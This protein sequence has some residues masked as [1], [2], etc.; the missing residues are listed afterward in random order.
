MALLE[1]CEATNT[2]PPYVCPDLIS[3]SAKLT[4]INLFFNFFPF[5]YLSTSPGINAFWSILC[6]DKQI[7]VAK[8]KMD[9][10]FF[11]RTEDWESM[12]TSFFT[13]LYFYLYFY[14]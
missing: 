9:I 12:D 13:A 1:G 6:Y 3:Q 8:E 7:I 10:Y 4:K 5:I 11:N 14:P 2:T